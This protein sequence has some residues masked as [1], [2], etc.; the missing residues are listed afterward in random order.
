M[1]T[2]QKQVR[3]ARRRLTWE[4]FLRLA[5]W[6]CFAW[7]WVAAAVIVADKFWPIG[8][9]YW[10]WPAAAMGLGLFSALVGTFIALIYG[11]R[12]VA[13]VITATLLAIGLYVLFDRTLDVP[14]PLGI[15]APLL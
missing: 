14:L 13:S 10:V 12:P 9:E 1:G 11:G 2:I 3:A 8:V 15:L 6:C 7:L 5:P 4:R